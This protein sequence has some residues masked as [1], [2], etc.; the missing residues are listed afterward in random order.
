MFQVLFLRKEFGTN[1]AIHFNSEDGLSL[2]PVGE[3]K[4]SYKVLTNLTSFAGL[5]LSDASFWKAWG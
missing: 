2:R 1:Q 4:K 5:L 3:A